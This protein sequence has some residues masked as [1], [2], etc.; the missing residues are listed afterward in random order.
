MSRPASSWFAIARGLP[1]DER[2]SR[3][4]EELIPLRACIDSH[5]RRTAQPQNPG[6]DR[7]STQ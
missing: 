3:I 1:V 7:G 2:L 6:T 4:D 5:R